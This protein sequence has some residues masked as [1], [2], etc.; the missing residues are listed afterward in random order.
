MVY[1]QTSKLHL[2]SSLSPVLVD[3]ESCHTGTLLCA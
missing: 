3:V 1:D 2:P